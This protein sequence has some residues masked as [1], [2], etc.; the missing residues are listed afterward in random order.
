MPAC[1]LRSANHSLAYVTLLP[2]FC[3]LFSKGLN[4]DLTGWLHPFSWDKWTPRQKDH[5]E[6]H[7]AYCDNMLPTRRM[8]W[9]QL[10][11][12]L[13]SASPAFFSLLLK[14]FQ[15]HLRL[16]VEMIFLLV[17]RKKI[18]RRF[19]ICYDYTEVE[20]EYELEVSVIWVPLL[21]SSRK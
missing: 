11:L 8:A 13:P 9:G 6:I 18:N 21:E 3:L 2:L 12:P 15:G 20:S 16:L 14:L 1:F 17:S 5:W 10:S 19:N 7:M 4:S